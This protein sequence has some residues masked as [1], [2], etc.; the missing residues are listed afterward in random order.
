MSAPC[1]KDLLKN[2]AFGVLAVL[3]G[4][5]V[6][7]LSWFACAY[8]AGALASLTWRVLLLGWASAS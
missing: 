4:L 3:R 6:C 5:A 1:L 2:F 8:I 7:L